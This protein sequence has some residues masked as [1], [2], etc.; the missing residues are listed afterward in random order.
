[1][2]KHHIIYLPGIGDHK[3]YF[4]PQILNFWK[5]FGVTPHYH[6]VIWRG[7]E[8]FGIKL[9]RITKLI[10]ELFA[11]GYLVS[12]VGV[13]A[14]ATA[15]FNAYMQ[16]PEI[17]NKVVYICGKLRRPETVGQYYYKTNPAFIQSLKKVQPQISK[18][19]A[20]DS[21]KMLSL[22]PFFDQTVPIA[23]MTLPKVKNLQMLSF[24][25]IPSI[26]I[27]LIFYAPVICLFFKKG[28]KNE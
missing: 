6:P 27:G 23:D 12:L 7:D 13:S 21:S 17:V 18:L 20:K 8:D 2:S 15:A 24:Y 28:N 19:S 1:V 10:D 4:Q 16:R 3:P 25:H 5:I 11:K 26:F 9:E 14:G 22:R